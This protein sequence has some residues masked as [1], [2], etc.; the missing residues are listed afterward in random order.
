[1]LESMS[2][3]GRAIAEKGR[4]LEDVMGAGRFLWAPLPNELPQ[5][6]WLGASLPYGRSPSSSTVTAPL[7]ILPLAWRAASLDAIA[8]LAGPIDGREATVPPFVREAFRIFWEGG[9]EP[10]PEEL[11]P[12]AQDESAGLQLRSDGEYRRLALEIIQSQA[13]KRMSSKAGRK[14]KRAIGRLM[15][16]ALSGG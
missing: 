4:R 9:E 14:R 3:I 7:S 15:H 10:A 1:M 16:R 2:A 8:E 11:A 6:T 13:W 12:A 5:I